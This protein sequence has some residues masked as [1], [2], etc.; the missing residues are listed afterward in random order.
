MDLDKYNY[1]IGV[2]AISISLLS[3]VIHS[4]RIIKSRCCKTECLINFQ[5]QNNNNSNNI[6][7]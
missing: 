6:D 7:V 1:D 4:I 2:V 3:A 5:K